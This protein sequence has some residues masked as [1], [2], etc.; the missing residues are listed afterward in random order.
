MLHIR[1]SPLLSITYLGTAN[2]YGQSART[3]PRHPG[4]PPTHT[5][6]VGRGRTP[7]DF[8]TGPRLLILEGAYVGIVRIL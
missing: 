3:V 1:D 8:V 7:V 5:G 6:G 4:Y 2:C